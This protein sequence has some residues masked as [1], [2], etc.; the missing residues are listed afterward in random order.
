MNKEKN[1]E[2]MTEWIAVV[3]RQNGG[4]IYIFYITRNTI[5]FI[6]KSLQNCIYLFIY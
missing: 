1:K 3:D 6:D 5:A 4:N 2:W